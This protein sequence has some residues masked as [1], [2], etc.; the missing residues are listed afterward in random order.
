MWKKILIVGFGESGRWLA[1]FLE[2]KGVA[3]TIYD[4]KLWQESDFNDID[5]AFISPGIPKS[6][7][8]RH[9]IFDLLGKHCIPVISDYDILYFFKPQSVF[10]GVTGTAGKTTTT[11]L[12]NH[13]L[14]HAGVSNHLC[15]N[16]GIDIFNE[17]SDFFVMELG[18]A[19]LEEVQFLSFHCGV[20]TNFSPDHIDFFDCK[21]RYISA[22]LNI[23]RKKPDYEQSF[24]LGAGCPSLE[25][26]S[27]N[28]YEINSKNIPEG[29][30][31]LEHNLQNIKVAYSVA[32]KFSE[33][34]SL[35]SLNTFQM[36]K[37]R[38]KF[39]GSVNNATIINDSKATNEMAV[40]AAFNSFDNIFW[41][42]GGRFKSFDFNFIKPYKNKIT[43]CLCFGQNGPDMHKF[44]QTV[45][46]QSQ[47]VDTMEDSEIL[48]E[49]WIK[50]GD[51]KCILFCPLG[52]SFDQFKSYEHRGEVFDS[53]IQ[54]IIEK[55]NQTPHT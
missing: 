37:F 21:E 44:L 55:L 31:R 54:K 38:Q 24:Y 52:Q 9:E 47:L 22:K 18:A 32:K 7:L 12:I 33:N 2:K 5:C 40:E 42:V 6:P 26:R 20:I 45:G 48:L 13:F 30:L 53:L 34:V 16:L 43:T 50:G 28:L 39:L 8:K 10:I 29:P 36:A 51:K 3:F 11:M 17:N 23:L 25:V 1:K 46:I 27:L 14:T 49:Q 4:D 41:I 35:E 19:Q 15:G